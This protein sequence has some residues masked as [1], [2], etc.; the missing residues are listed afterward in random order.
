MTNEEWLNT[1]ST[2]E[3]AKFIARS[4]N[5]CSYDGDNGYCSDSLNVC[6]NGIKEWLKREHIEPMPEL[7]VG[8]IIV[9]LLDKGLINKIVVA[10]IVMGDKHA[11]D[12][13]GVMYNLKDLNIRA[14]KR[15]NN[16]NERVETIWRCDNDR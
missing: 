2:E 9:V 5:L 3:K 12:L 6:K 14:I 11:S 1:L 4:C 10:L 16:T 13:N 15:M 7:Q 8:D